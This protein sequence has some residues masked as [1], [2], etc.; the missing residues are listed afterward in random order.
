MEQDKYVAQKK[1]AKNNIKKL[2]CSFQATFVDDFKNACNKLGVTQA[3]VIRKT[4]QEIIDKANK[5]G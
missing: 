5:K 4:M 2:S 3:E 1:Y